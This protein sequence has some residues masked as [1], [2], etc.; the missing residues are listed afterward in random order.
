MEFS[1]HSDTDL[2]RH[3][4]AGSAPAF[5]T[6]VH[7]HA[8]QVHAVFSHAPD[9]HARVTA[10]F[11]DAMK[12][13]DSLGEEAEVGSTLLEIAGA[14]GGDATSGASEPSQLSDDEVDAIWAQLYRRWPSGRARPA[15]PSA[16]PRAALVATLVAVGFLLP[17]MVL[18]AG[19]TEE[20][21]LE[22][23]VAKPYEEAEPE[24][25]EDAERAQDT[26]DDGDPPEQPLL[27]IPD[28]D[29]P[30]DPIP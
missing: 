2:V 8:P 11:L 26:L 3:A 30:G 15:L 16:A 22:H 12:R 23:I 24:N 10:T 4:S 27:P 18:A 5:A 29:M 21:E 14:R 6:I 25:A 28:P 20:V 7:R 19:A 13:L 1:K 9:P 17:R